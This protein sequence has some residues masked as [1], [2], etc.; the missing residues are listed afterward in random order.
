MSLTLV[1]QRKVFVNFL[2]MKVEV[3][4]TFK[5]QKLDV[6]NPIKLIMVE[7]MIIYSSKSSVQI[8]KSK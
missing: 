7:S 1:I 3:F 5:M 8:M 6:E 2:K 4:S